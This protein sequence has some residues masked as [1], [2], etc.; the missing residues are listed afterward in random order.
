MENGINV[1]YT[2]N[3]PKEFDE[4]VLTKNLNSNVTKEG[5]VIKGT[6]T[7]TNSNSAIYI[8]LPK[9]YFTD[10]SNIG[11]LI[12]DAIIFVL[13]TAITIL[14][15]VFYKKIPNK[16]I[17]FVSALS[18]IFTLTIPCYLYY[19][20]NLLLLLF[21]TILVFLTLFLLTKSSIAALLIQCI[22]GLILFGIQL[23]LIPFYLTDI[24]LC[25]AII[26]SFIHLVTIPIL[27]KKKKSLDV[28]GG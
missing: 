23:V 15:A 6:G 13:I 5:T 17:Y 28:Y 22:S 10:T 19:G 11:P 12:V 9:D 8:N 1:N 2:I 14:I 27:I 20:V 25:F 26:V 4:E 7:T 24:C 21:N 16:A 18:L 3:M